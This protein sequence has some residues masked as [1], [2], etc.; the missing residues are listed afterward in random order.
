[1]IVK[2]I[3]LGFVTLAVVSAV[4]FFAVYLLPGDL[5]EEI[6][7]QA[8]TPETVANIRRELGLDRPPIERYVDWITGLLSGDFGRS[9]ANGRPIAE[10]AGMRLVN[11]LYLA[12]FAA[13]VSIPL[14]LTLGIVAALYREKLIDRSINVAALT[15]ISLPEFFI[16]YILIFALTVKAGWLPSLATV[17]AD[18][19]L[20]E[21]MFRSILPV[22]TLT[23]AVA[24]HVM[25]LT[26]AAIVNLLASPYIEMARLK[27]LKPWRVILRHA[28]PNALAPI[29]NVVV[30]NLAYLIVG[31][32]VVEV[33]F[34]Y[35]GLGQL[36]VDSVGKRD[37]PVVQ[38][39]CLF[40]AST[41]I[42]LNLV[43]DVATIAADPRLLHRR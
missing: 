6:L 24:A 39:T 29:I 30:L 5:A 3:G 13:A 14:S 4:V 18:T 42:M 40:F 2:R 36:M 32:V 8:A 1:M 21:R 11:T 22:L 35:P 25:R 34:A 23:L 15:A 37:V 43:A 26:R 33:V 7:G 19:P 41:Y 16:A 38:A 9:L 10:L 20:G 31:V 27:G 17:S 28:L 12:G